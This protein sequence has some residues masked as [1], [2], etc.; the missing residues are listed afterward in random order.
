MRCFCLIFV[1][2]CRIIYWNRSMI[3]L[4]AAFRWESLKYTMA[5]FLI[6]GSLYYYIFE[7]NIPLIHIQSLLNTVLRLRLEKTFQ[8][9]CQKHRFSRSL[10]FC[11]NEIEKYFKLITFSLFSINHKQSNHYYYW[12]LMFAFSNKTSDGRLNIYINYL[13]IISY[14][15]WRMRVKNENLLSR[16]CDWKKTALL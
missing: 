15:Q 6:L 12:F 7:I 10:E 9:F 13:F 3:F 11:Y 4:F 2:I 8:S 5:A 16:N 1:S 14:W